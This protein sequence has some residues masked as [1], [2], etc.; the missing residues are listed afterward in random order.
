M[1]FGEMARGGSTS[2]DF[3]RTT[4]QAMTCLIVGYSSR[5]SN[6]REASDVDAHIDVAQW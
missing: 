2:T 6:H 4:K 5:R 1:Q 3:K